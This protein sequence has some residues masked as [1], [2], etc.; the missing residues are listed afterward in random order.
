MKI[1]LLAHIRHPIAEPFMGGMESHTHHLANALVDRGHEVILLASADS[2][3]KAKLTPILSE[4][5][6]ATRPWHLSH[7]TAGFFDFQTQV[8]ARAFELIKQIKPDVIH[9]NGLHHDPIKYAFHAKFAMVSAM[10]VPPFKYLSDSIHRHKAAH[11]R[12]TATS[13]AHFDQWQFDHDRASVVPN[14]VSCRPRSAA[15][16]GR[17]LW[18]GRIAQTKGLHFAIDAAVQAQV[19]LDIV[20][21]IEEQDYFDQYIAQ[22]LADHESVT[23]HGLRDS[24]QV[25]RMMSAAS[26]FVFTPMWEE[27][28]GLVAVEAMAQS[29][30]V[31]GFDSGAVKEVVAEAG[32]IVAAGDTQALSLAITKAQSISGEVC[33]QRARQH[34][35]VEA[36]VSGYEREYQKAIRGL[37]HT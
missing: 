36:M 9:N 1:A 15:Q 23:Y 14:G 16:T 35:S 18:V 29:T 13:K 19:G 28:F 27:P 10:H 34:F 11:L 12:Y 5:Y 37:A 21:P 4:H 32:V 3:T 26:V 17:A 20:G 2:H 7:K 24:D 6:E 30:P 22:R 33:A 31:A 25:S 8:F